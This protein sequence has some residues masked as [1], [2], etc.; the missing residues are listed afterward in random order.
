MFKE[1]TEL[2]VVEKPEALI[3]YEE[4]EKE[5]KD[6]IEANPFIEC[7]R[8]TY[9][10]A[11][12][13]RTALRTARTDIEKDVKMIRSRLEQ[14][15]DAVSNFGK[16]LIDIVSPAEEKQQA[17]VKRYETEVEAEKERARLAEQERVNSIRAKIENWYQKIH[18]FILSCKSSEDCNTA[19]FQIN[20]TSSQ[21]TTEEYQELC[22]E[23]NM[24][25]G[26]LRNELKAKVSA[27]KE[28]EDLRRQKAEQEEENRKLEEQKKKAEQ[29]KQD[30]LNANLLLEAKMDYFELIGVR[31]PEDRS[32]EWIR[33]AIEQEKASRAKKKTP[34]PVE[35]ELTQMAEHQEEILV[36][37]QESQNQVK[38]EEMKV[39]PVE[40]K[41]KGTGAPF[42][43][44]IPAPAMSVDIPTID[45]I[46][47]SSEE[48][49]ALSDQY[50]LKFR[51]HSV[52]L[53][54]GEMDKKVTTSL[55]KTLMAGFI[56]EV[57]A[58]CEKYRKMTEN[59]TA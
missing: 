17:E 38:D 47:K 7:T 13:R 14:V 41:F 56:E 28:A 35:E 20:A 1:E 29:E 26:A 9:E 40:T 22:G 49:E 45:E 8:E 16:K 43:E 39:K 5:I 18:Q 32:V 44:P 2:A 55:G 11:K 50:V 53:F 12:K 27:V 46:H 59:L 10:E 51:I 34:D 54:L 15:K 37:K 33:D 30:A 23:A 3:K 57:E 42:D 6:L 4:K 31:P 25:I 36:P 58:V 48:A 19:E 24:R 52:S 21:I